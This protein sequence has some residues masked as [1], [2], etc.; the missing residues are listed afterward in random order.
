MRWLQLHATRPFV[1]GTPLA[2]VDAARQAVPQTVV[3]R[4]R[5]SLVNRLRRMVLAFAAL[6]MLLVVLVT[7][8]GQLLA[9]R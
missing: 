7:V 9:Q 8:G 3:L 6:I 1:R 2:R 4:R 5:R